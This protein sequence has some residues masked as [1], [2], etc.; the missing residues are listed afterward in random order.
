MSSMVEPSMLRD[1]HFVRERVANGLLHIDYVLS[2][3]Q[4]GDKFTKALP[5]Q[6]LENFKYNIKL[7]KV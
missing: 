5:V 4:I 2:G 1:Y 3:D 6:S 7:T